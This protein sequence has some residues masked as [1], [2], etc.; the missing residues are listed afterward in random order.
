MI[1]KFK[2]LTTD[3]KVM[4]L[5]MIAACILS[6]FFPWSKV[7]IAATVAIMSCVMAFIHGIKYY[8]TK[9]LVVFFVICW[10]VSN[11]F[12]GF[13]VAYGFP[14]G[15]YHYTLAGPRI[16]DV[17]IVIMPAY[18]GMGYFAW[19]LSLVINRVYEKKLSGAKTFLV[20]F[21]SALI[22][23][24]WDVVL[25][26]TA[27]TLNGNWI[28]ED[29]GTIFNIPVSNFAGWFFVVYLFMQIFA[30]YISK[31]DK[32]ERSMKEYPSV[33]W[34]AA[35]LTYMMQGLTYVET[36]IVR[37][38]NLEIWHYAGLISV[39]TMCFVAWI[40]FIMIHDH[41]KELEK[42]KN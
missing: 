16:W 10:V 41:L 32:K 8:G 20:P 7:M 26:P 34:Y 30:I 28:W 39:F 42:N 37:T 19:V 14:F 31:A 33:F 36:A 12:E 13:S 5:L 15:N 4:L 35:P 24:M 38:D 17:P 29:G 27:S 9:N 3:M 18:F 23:V 40:G 22:M 1:Q 25:D 11:F 6:I 21:T 2:S